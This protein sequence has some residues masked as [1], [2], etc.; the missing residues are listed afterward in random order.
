MENLCLECPVKGMCCYFSIQLK[1]Y[2]IVLSNQACKWLDKNTGLCT[3]YEHRK[4][5]FKYC[6]GEDKDEMFDVGALPKECLF[7]K[8]LHRKEARPK[9]RLGKV[10]HKL[11]PNDIKIYNEYNTAPN[12]MEFYENNY[13]K[14]GIKKMEVK[15]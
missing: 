6:Y 10:I 7:L 8:Q 4:E 15:V 12:F 14:I 5:H 13:N 2:N 3:D 1:G 11:T 9:I